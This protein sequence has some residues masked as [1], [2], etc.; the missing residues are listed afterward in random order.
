MRYGILATIGLVGFLIQSVLGAYL[1]I[2][3]AM[4]SPLLQITVTLGL[5]FG[6]RIGLGT[7][8]IGGLLLDLTAGRLIGLHLLSMGLVGLLIGLLEEKVFKENWFLAGLVGAGSA[9]LA[10]GLNFLCLAL[11]G[12]RF[13]PVHTLVGAILPSALY[14]GLLTMLVYSQVYRYYQYLRPNPRGTIVLRR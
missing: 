5:L 13:D 14:D 2:G 11:L 6:W 1:S 4:P 8:L 12:W 9:I 3:G 7:G 10:H